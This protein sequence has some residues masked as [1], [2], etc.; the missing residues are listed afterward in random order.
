MS[1]DDGEVSVADYLAEWL[2]RRRSRLSP[3]THQS[4]RQTIAC[5]L[6]PHLGHLAPGQ[7]DRRLLE[8][9]YA[10][11]LTGG[12]TDGRPL[13]PSTVKYVHA[14][15]SRAL[16]DARIDGLIATNPARLARPPRHDPRQV[17]LAEE[18]KVWTPEEAAR[19]LAFVDDHRWRAL[20]HLALGTGARRGELLGLRWQDVD[21][22]AAQVRIRRALS[23]VDGVTRLLATK[24]ARVRC[25]S[26]G[27]SVVEALRRHREEQ[28]RLR[29]AAD[30]WDNEW[31][32]V[33]TDASGRPIDPKRVTDEFRTL[34][35]RAPVPVVRFHDLRHA[36]ATILV[37]EGVPLKVV[38]ERLGHTH[39]AISMDIY[40]H[41]LPA[42]DADAAAR[43]EA[44]LDRGSAG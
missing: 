2:E 16:E 36:H 23:V 4:Y 38:S 7:I 42:M 12:G 29:A 34:V 44:A 21:L 3:T 37:A 18:L 39:I 13:S 5:Y 24:T 35:R 9:L 26:V 33:F 6:T 8:G 30:R 28:E 27:G 19:F 41:V 11:L 15:I 10:H 17:T 40:G 43:F 20:F 14:V 31:G 32:L 1:A 25:L 22:D